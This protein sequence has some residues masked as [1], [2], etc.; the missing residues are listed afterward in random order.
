MYLQKILNLTDDL[1]Q[2]WIKVPG[3]FELRCFVPVSG[4]RV[5][6]ELCKQL[7]KVKGVLN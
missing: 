2:V 4:A 7:C 5:P 6:N 3:E 1:I